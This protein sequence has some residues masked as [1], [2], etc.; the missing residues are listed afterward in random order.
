MNLPTHQSQ[1]SP[2]PI[3]G[4]RSGLGR[5]FYIMRNIIPIK[6]IHYWLSLS[7]VVI[8]PYGHIKL[9]FFQG[10]GL[11]IGAVVGHLSPSFM[12]FHNCSA[13][14]KARMRRLL[15]SDSDVASPLIHAPNEWSYSNRSSCV[16]RNHLSKNFASFQ[17]VRYNKT[18]LHQCS[19]Q[20]FRITF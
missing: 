3:A 9:N 5:S 18:T 15:S 17:A 20:S 2:S 4:L 16:G 8:I 1:A 10:L 19:L 7:F 11:F 6:H 13:K 12:S 14:S